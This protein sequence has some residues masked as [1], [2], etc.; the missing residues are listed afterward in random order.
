MLFTLISSLPIANTK[1]VTFSEEGCMSI[2]LAWV[3]V[4]VLVWVSSSSSLYPISIYRSSDSQTHE[5]HLR[6]EV[7]LQYAKPKPA[8]VYVALPHARKPQSQYISAFRS[9]LVLLF[10]I[11]FL[12]LALLLSSASS[13][14][15]QTSYIYVT[16]PCHHGR[17]YCTNCLSCNIRRHIN[18]K[19]KESSNKRF[20][21]KG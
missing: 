13:I 4:P 14:F 2:E 15:L 19:K 3:L 6:L 10:L 1:R 16:V 5:A 9:Y 12:F 21:T 8:H 7:L 20:Q 11:T 17:S 18:L